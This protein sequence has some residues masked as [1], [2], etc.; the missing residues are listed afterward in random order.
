[1]N[2]SVLLIALFLLFSSI[3]QSLVPAENQFT[4]V[5]DPSLN[6]EYDVEYDA[7][8][9][10]SSI[11]AGAFQLAFYN[12]TPGAFTFAVRMGS[13]DPRT[14]YYGNKFYVPRW[15]WEANRGK[16]VGEMATFAL[17]A[18]GN[19]V[20][21]EADGRVAWQ[22]NTTN[23]DVVRFEL[24]P[25]GNM[26]LYNSKG[27]YVWQ[28]FDTATD[29][30]LVGQGLKLG[31]TTKLVSRASARDNSDGP[32]SLVMEKDTLVLYY[33]SPT[34]GMRYA[35][36]SF[37]DRFNTL[38]GALETV[39]FQCAPQT[40][41][42]VAFNLYL[43]YTVTDKSFFGSPVLVRPNWNVTYSMLRLGIDGSLKIYTYYIPVERTKWEV[44]YSL[45]SEGY[46]GGCQLPEKCGKFGLCMSDMCV[47]CPTETGSTE[48]SSSC[49][50]RTVSALACANKAFKFNKLVG[51]DHFMSAFTQGENVSESA[52]GSKCTTDCKCAGYF[53]HQAESKCWVAYDLKTLTRNN[54][55]THIGYIK[56]PK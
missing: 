43:N 38:T 19:L 18:N 13:A 4:F 25:N 52:C 39:T 51:V 3:S 47:G 56:V 14:I 55:S 53:Y 40:D 7:T 32:Y 31:G 46:A 6:G 22:T 10:I 34:S 54:N 50:P 41:E 21:T 11:A 1:M 28:S 45:F 2:S 36:Y 26:V 42:N 48:W 5:N 8:Y 44:T 37:A 49:Q 9:T 17:L 33:T 20:I 12:T 27:A 30:L 35:Y 24:L 15:V 23:K 29:T 16:P